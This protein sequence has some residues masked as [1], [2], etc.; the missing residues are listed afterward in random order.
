LWYIFHP[1]AKSSFGPCSSDNLQEMYTAGMLDGQS[2]L[3]F[4]DV[5]SLK[6]TVPFSFFKLKDMESTKFLKRI[7][8]SE[9]LKK[10]IKIPVGFP[11]E[12]FN[13]KNS[14]KNSRKVSS[15]N[16][17]EKERKNSNNFNNNKQN[18]NVQV[19]KNL[20]NEKKSNTNTNTNN[21]TKN[22]NN[23][24]KKKG[25]FTKINYLIN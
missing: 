23:E 19:A 5:Y 6:N 20:D 1:V 24:N 7:E 9:I 2:E 21:N 13:L 4:I 14:K 10:A 3:R 12:D 16:Y 22:N 18:E 17:E 15:N 8:P 25:N 11:N